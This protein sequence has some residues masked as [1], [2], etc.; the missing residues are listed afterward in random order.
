MSNPFRCDPSYLPSLQDYSNLVTTILTI[1][2]SDLPDR[3]LPS[4]FT[5]ID[6]NDE[7]FYLTK[8]TI[9]P[10]PTLPPSLKM[11]YNW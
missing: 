3:P 1:D 8:T 5:S 4:L 11:N 10:S 2:S 6:S 7:V 9:V